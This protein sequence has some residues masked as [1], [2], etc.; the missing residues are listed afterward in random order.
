MADVQV[1]IAQAGPLPIKVSTDIGS[2]GP[3]VLT[4]AGS[5]WSTSANQLIGVSLS[6]DGEPVANAQIFSNGPTTHRAVVP[7]TLPYTFTYGSHTFE[8]TAMNAQTT[9][10]LNDL[11]RLTVQY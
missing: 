11:F 5:V 2:D 7:M 1:I 9:T 6:I 3:C 8:L 4:L 10:D